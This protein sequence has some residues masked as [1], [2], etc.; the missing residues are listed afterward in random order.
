MAK[1]I[2]TYIWTTISD[3]YIIK[4]I[5]GAVVAVLASIYGSY[6]DLLNLVLIL[7]GIDFFLGFGRSMINRRTSS[8]RAFTGALKF[9]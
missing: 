6:T 7:F 3:I 2:L 8:K 4:F 1:S 9:L 5:A